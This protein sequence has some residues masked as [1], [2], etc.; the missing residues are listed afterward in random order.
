MSPT[1]KDR[2]IPNLNTYLRNSK[3]FQQQM[4]NLLT[5]KLLQDKFYIID[6]KKI[7]ILID[8]WKKG[9]DTDPMFIFSLLTLH[10]FFKKIDNEK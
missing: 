10:G 4:D 6:W 9:I 8:N 2:T 3:Y 1:L 7:N 5:N